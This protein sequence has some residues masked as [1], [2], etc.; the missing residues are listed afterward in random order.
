M[1]SANA[2]RVCGGD[3]F[4]PP[5]TK[6]FSGAS[7]ALD[8]AG[9]VAMCRYGGFPWKVADYVRLAASY[10]WDWYSQMDLC[11]EPAISTDRSEVR[12]RQDETVRLLG[13]CRREAESLGIG[14]PMPVLQ[15]WRPTDYLRCVEAMGDLP[16]LVGVGS[17]CR[18]HLSGPSGL[19]AV[20]NRL[21]RELPKGVYLHLFGVKG[22]AIAKL[23]GHERIHSVDSMAWDFRA[24]FLALE[25]DRAKDIPLRIE[26]MRSWYRRQ[27]ESL[28]QQVQ[29]KD[30]PR[31]KSARQRQQRARSR[32]ATRGL[33]QTNLWLT[34]DLLDFVDSEKEQHENR[35]DCVR[36]LLTELAVKMRD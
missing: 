22:S 26:S 3:T 7:V 30:P 36:R 1:V 29:G 32:R 14:P 9:F 25:S 16:A 35:S 20:V 19:L 18:R 2:F 17:V 10:P 12:R 15:G 28:P 27:I 23:A 5:S 8:S 6:L 34:E 33:R 11:C 13:E 31:D 4:R 21:D 24:R